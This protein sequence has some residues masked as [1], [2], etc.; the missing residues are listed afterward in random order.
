M[1]TP[2]FA[3]LVAAAAVSG[4]DTQPTRAESAIQPKAE[5]RFIDLPDFDRTLTDSLRAP[6]PRVD[7]AFYDRVSPS[8]V[9]ER[10]QAWLAAVEAGGGRVSVTP[11]ASVVTALNPL[12][13]VKAISTL[14]SAS[15]MARE[16]S[17]QQQFQAAHAYDA[18]ILL[19][20][21]Y[22]GDAVVDKVVFVQRAK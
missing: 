19:R 5:L 14:W 12:L 3:L 9:P 10:L 16:M 17:V 13:L 15:K 1:K 18:K 22:Q 21:D 2:L 20:Y 11:P 7:V 4:C 6:L 8:A